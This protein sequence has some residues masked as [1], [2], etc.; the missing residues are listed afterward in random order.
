M[1]NYIHHGDEMGFGKTG[2][3]KFMTSEFQ[4]Y[5]FVTGKGNK[6]LGTEY[7]LR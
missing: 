2:G 4:I 7:L 3:T 1:Q 5:K 6:L